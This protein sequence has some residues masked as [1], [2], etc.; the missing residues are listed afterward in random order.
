MVDWWARQMMTPQDVRVRK[1]WLDR[2]GNGTE[3]E[4]WRVHLVEV[5]IACDRRD[6]HLMWRLTASHYGFVPAPMAKVDAAELGHFAQRC[7]H[8]GGT[9]FEADDPC[10]FCDASGRDLTRFV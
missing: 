2:A 7:P 5:G 9:G 3:R 8:C 1:G 10:E 6:Y 4:R